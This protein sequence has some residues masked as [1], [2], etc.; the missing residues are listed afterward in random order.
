MTF[1]GGVIKKRR[2]AKSEKSGCIREPKNCV[3][4]VSFCMHCV[5]TNLQN[6]C[7]T[8]PSIKMSFCIRFCRI[9]NFFYCTVQH[10]GAKYKRR[11][12]EE[13]RPPTCCQH[14]TPNFR[15]ENNKPKTPPLHLF[16]SGRQNYKRMK[17]IV[18]IMISYLMM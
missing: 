13:D 4:S 3:P 14:F 2:G 5:I 8:M 11:K 1:V 17:I 10:E 6:L 9:K 7:S 16:G 12:K 15:Q 18:T